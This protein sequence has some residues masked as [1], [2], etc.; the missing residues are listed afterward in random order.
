MN[1]FTKKELNAVRHA[2][3][4]ALMATPYM[5]QNDYQCG[6]VYRIYQIP[7]TFSALLVW[8]T[9]HLVLCED[10]LRSLGFTTFND[11]H[12]EALFRFDRQKKCIDFFTRR[13]RDYRP[14]NQLPYQDVSASEPSNDVVLQTL[15]PYEAISP[16]D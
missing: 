15:F 5:Q 4:E 9:S 8:S 12:I 14:E 16:S 1:N 7:G 10:L 6:T 11:I 2:A 13:L 3:F